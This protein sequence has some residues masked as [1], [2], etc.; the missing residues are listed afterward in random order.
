MLVYQRVSIIDLGVMKMGAL[1]GMIMFL[2]TG[3]L[4]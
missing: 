3:K 1:D 4:T 2:T